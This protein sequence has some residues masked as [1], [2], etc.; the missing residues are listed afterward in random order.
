M[1]DDN[2]TGDAGHPTT[3]IFALPADAPEP[4]RVVH[5]DFGAASSAPPPAPPT[6]GGALDA[7]LRTITDGFTLLGRA[8]N[9][10]V[11]Q[12]VGRLEHHVGSLADRL[13]RAE[14]TASSAEAAVHERV[15]GAE[16]MVRSTAAATQAQLTEQSDQTDRL[17]L[18][19]ADHAERFA[20][21]ETD[22]AS[23]AAEIG[24]LTAEIGHLTAENTRLATRA[25]RLTAG[26]VVVGLIAAAAV[27]AA[28]V[29]W[30]LGAK[31]AAALGGQ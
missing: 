23:R 21:L 20:R 24:D 12:H 5:A 15:Q 22:A 29:G 14:T 26:L 16:D 18:T 7:P 8:I 9:Q 28:W 25:G 1:D 19:L 3:D 17:N 2:A 31:V 11:E 13:D 6:E 4:P 30:P 10:A 27:A